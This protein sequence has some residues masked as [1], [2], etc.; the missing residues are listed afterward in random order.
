VPS[1][2]AASDVCGNAEPDGADLGAV[3]WVDGVIVPRGAVAI[4]PDDK[5]LTGAGVFEAIKVVDGVP[6][7]LRRHLE[8]L[9]ASAAPLG[10]PIDIERVREGVVTVLACAD[11]VTT[12]R[13]WLR[14]TVTAGP[15]AWPPPAPATRP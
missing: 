1:Q 7:A 2:P 4:R 6:F 5:G 10:L 11:A 14:I 8:R 15:P 13:R 9:V 3:A 12:S